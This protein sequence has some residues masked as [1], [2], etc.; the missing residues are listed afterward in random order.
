VGTRVAVGRAQVAR[1]IRAAAP[2]LFDLAAPVTARGPWLTAVLNVQSARPVP[3][4]RPRAVVVEQARGGRPEAA[5]LLASRRRGPATALT[6]L[7]QTAGPLPGGHPTS[8]LYARDDAGAR[9]LA[10]AIV[11]LLSRVRGPWTLRLS[12]LPLGD[13]TVGHLAAAL[14]G[15][16]L[17]TS[18]NRRLVDDLDSVADVV[19]S[20]DP[21]E[22]ER[23]LPVVLERVPPAERSFLRACAR[24][25]AA[26]GQLELAVVPAGTGA[27]AVLLTLLDGGGSNPTRWPWWG[28]SD[29]GGLRQEL[30]VP[31]VTLAASAGWLE[32]ARRR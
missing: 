11:D 10:E 4:V 5:A 32:L 30:G 13:A 23:W 2:L 17:A 1:E 8:V 15:A 20:C 22:L 6:L 28:S 26:I 16:H 24:V 18:R 31:G 7:G 21:A 25:H 12:G 19:R 3:R 9:R 27:T 14:P 29:L